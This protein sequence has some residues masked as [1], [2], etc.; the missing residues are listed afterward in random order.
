MF[1]L[2]PSDY[3]EEEFIHFIRR[4]NGMYND[5]K[6]RNDST[7]VHPKYDMHEVPFSTIEHLKLDNYG[8]NVPFTRNNVVNLERYILRY[9]QPIIGSDAVMLLLNLWEYCNKE[10]G[11]DICYP[12]IPELAIMMNRSKPVITNTLQK[13]EDNN[14]IIIIHRLNKLSNNR[15]TSPV[16]KL[17]QTVPL[18][19]REQYRDLPDFLKKK[20][21]DYMVKFCNGAEMRNFS[22]DSNETIDELLS[23]SDKIISRKTRESI[24]KLIESDQQLE[25]LSN[26][27]PENLKPNFKRE[28][29]SHSLENNGMS[30]PVIDTFFDGCAS[31][32]AGDSNVIDM[33]VRSEDNKEVLKTG[34]SERNSKLLNDAL[35]SMYGQFESIRY[36]TVREYIYKILKG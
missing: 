20:H 36:Y 6:A 18:L 19:S 24:N 27:L 31:L 15:E 30:K 28:E 1:V 32:L 16:F 10:D 17:R 8:E 11:V 25:Y 22:H 2:K 14:F 7:R 23:H 26:N 33:I 4:S 35:E 12:K 21:D 5:V 29:L 3:K 13:L 9:W 34:L